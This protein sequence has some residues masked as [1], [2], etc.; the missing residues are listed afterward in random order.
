MKIAADRAKFLRQL[1]N[2]RDMLEREGGAG[3]TNQK[4][5]LLQRKIDQYD[6]Q[7]PMKT[8]YTKDSPGTGSKRKRLN[9]TAKNNQ[10]AGGGAGG[11]RDCAELEE[12]GYEVIPRVGDISDGKGGVM[13]LNFSSKV[14]QPLS[15]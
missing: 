7:N 12:H 14:R 11:T 6:S 10:G 1:Y 3:D 15:T 13:K 9:N 2:L 8:F 4:I 5:R